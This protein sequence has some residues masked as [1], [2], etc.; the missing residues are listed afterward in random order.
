MTTIPGVYLAVDLCYLPTWWGNYDPGYR[1]SIVSR[2]ASSSSSGGGSSGSFSMPSLPGSD[3]AASMTNSVQSFS[4]GV[5]GDVAAFTG[6]ITNKTNPIPVST[7]SGGGGGGGS[8]CACACA[9]A[10]CA[11]ACAGGGRYVF[12][13]FSEMYLLLN[14]LTN[15]IPD[16]A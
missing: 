12:N 2:S 4:A 5:I 1:T 15:V 3:F 11:C 10:G 7:S 6:G 14:R 13:I 9:C 16:R 8:H